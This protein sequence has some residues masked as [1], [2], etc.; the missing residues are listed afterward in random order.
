MTK[1]QVTALRVKEQGQVLQVAF[2]D[3]RNVVLPA[4]LLRVES[5]SAEVQGHGP[6]QKIHVTG[7]DN[8]RIR[9][10][11]PVGNYAVRI[12]FDDGHDTGLYTWEYLSQL[13][14]ITPGKN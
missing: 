4:T 1:V 11:Q 12:V 2:H 6:G 5:P 13:A 8:V 3:G 14:D 7:K 10:V 9:D